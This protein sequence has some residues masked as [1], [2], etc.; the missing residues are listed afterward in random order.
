MLEPVLSIQDGLSFYCA[1]VS[2]AQKR[3]KLVKT[4]IYANEADCFD[5]MY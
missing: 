1:A 2:Q 3:L 4:L 5:V